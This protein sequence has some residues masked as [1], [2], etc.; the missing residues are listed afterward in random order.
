[1]RG[2]RSSVTLGNSLDFVLLPDSER[3]TRGSLGGVDELVS[4]GL[5]DALQRAESGFAGTLDDQV[6]SLVDSAEGRDVDCLSAH[7]T[8]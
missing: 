8:T 2:C 5:L 6:D 4:K 7:G 1:M 3:S